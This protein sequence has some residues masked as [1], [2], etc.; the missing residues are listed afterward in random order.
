MKQYSVESLMNLH[1]M[2]EVIL[3][4]FDD[5][6]PGFPIRNSSLVSKVES[7]KLAG[8]LDSCFVLFGTLQQCAPTD[9]GVNR[10][11][12][13]TVRKDNSRYIV[14]RWSWKFKSTTGTRGALVRDWLSN[15]ELAG[16]VPTRLC[17]CAL[18]KSS[19]QNE[20]A[21]QCSSQFL[22]LNFTDWWRISN[23]KF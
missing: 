16:S 13:V 2:D 10:T 23:W 22:T 6:F 14:N 9:P 12:D 8:A 5:S 4:V 21:V 3:A 17:W 15:C 7:Q 19:K 11:H 20:T 1:W 18:L